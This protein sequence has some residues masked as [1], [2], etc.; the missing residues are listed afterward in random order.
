MPICVQDMCIYLVYIFKCIYT[1]PIWMYM[2]YMH[3][4]KY[5][6]HST[7]AAYGIH[8]HRLRKTSD[9]V[10]IFLKGWII[11]QLVIPVGQIHCRSGQPHR[12][13][14]QQSRIKQELMWQIPCFLFCFI[15]LFFYTVSQKDTIQQLQVP[16]KTDHSLVEH[17]CRN[18]CRYKQMF[19]KFIV[20]MNANQTESLQHNIQPSIIIVSC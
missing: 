9:I 19:H 7:Q 10:G 1:L 15:S 14:P 4:H 8:H 11:L 3:I 5:F 17:I 12:T 20:L 18:L 16:L 13:D 2:Q 6:T